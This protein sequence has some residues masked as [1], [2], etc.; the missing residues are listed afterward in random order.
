[1]AKHRL[2]A[3]ALYLEDSGVTVNGVSFWGSPYQPEFNNWA[4]NLPRGEEIQK[5]W[6]MI[7]TG[8][9]ILITHGP[10]WGRCDRSNGAWVDDGHLGCVDLTYAVERIMPQHHIFGHIHGGHGYARDMATSYH[11]VAVMNEAYRIVHPATVID[12]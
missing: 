10:P 4:F 7:P 11:N 6:D 9:D 3:S 8:T 2:S 12:L 5:H 1:L